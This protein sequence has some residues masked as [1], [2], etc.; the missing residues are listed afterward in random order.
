MSKLD[1]FLANA[2]QTHQLQL[3]S[4]LG[5]RSLYV[6]A[7]DIAGCPR[8]A[9]LGKKQPPN[10]D[11]KTLL[12]FARGHVAQSMYGEFFRAGGA[13]FEEEVEVRHPEFPEI[14]CHIDFLFHTNNKKKR[15]H[16]VEMKSIS[17]IPDE[18][19][20][21]W[22]DQ[23]HVQ[24]GLLKLNHKDDVEI[25]GSILVV[26][27][28]AGEYREFNGYN[29]NELVFKHLIEKGAHIYSAMKGECEPKTEPSFL[30]GYC[31][32]RTDCPAHPVGSPVELPTD[33]HEAGKAYLELNEQKRT[34]ES[35]LNALKD[36][37]LSYTGGSFKAIT[38]DFSMV[39]AKVSES[40]TVDSKK[41]KAR[42]PDIYEQVTKPKN[43]FV[44][45]E[46]KPLIA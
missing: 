13:N 39:A 17:G 32:F 26:D 46:I 31:S 34:I 6:G 9:G 37:I 22:I 14:L 25:G 42:Y 1:S 10:H 11:I 12:R 15:L 7:S 36:S 18:P 44:K 28:N 43:G 40:V 38:D 19:H 45:L 20:S 35:Q 3:S 8:K 2:I 29:P 21:S 41:L 23:L 16:V 27:L 30:C 33:I 4:H 24:M 5:D